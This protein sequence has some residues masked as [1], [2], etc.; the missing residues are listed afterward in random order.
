MDCDGELARSP[1]PRWRTKSPGG[2]EGLCS[3]FF[4]CPGCGKL[5]WHGTHWESIK[6]RLGR[7][8][9]LARGGPMSSEGPTG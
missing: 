8:A 3:E 2:Y 6:D 5:Y 9:E 1:L 7:A 4:R